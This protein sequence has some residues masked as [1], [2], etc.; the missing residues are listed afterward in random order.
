PGG[1]RGHGRSAD[2]AAHVSFV[3]RAQRVHPA[4]SRH[5]R[6]IARVL[7]V[8]TIFSA[9]AAASGWL[10]RPEPEIA[11]VPLA[12]L[13]ASIDG[14]SS[15]ELPLETKVLDTLGLDDHVNRVYERSVSPP[16]SLYIG[17]YK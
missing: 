10:S 12:D 5:N 3:V 11:R 14:C 13:A 16:V 1:W 17:F 2:G 8:V 4:R 9:T 6:M 7:I 15:R